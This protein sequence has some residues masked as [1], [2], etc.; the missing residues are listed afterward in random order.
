VWTLF[1]LAATIPLAAGRT[2]AGRDDLGVRGRGLASLSLGAGG[3]S[4]LQAEHRESR[5][6]RPMPPLARLNDP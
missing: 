2:Q 4:G 5:S 3:V 6:S 1:L